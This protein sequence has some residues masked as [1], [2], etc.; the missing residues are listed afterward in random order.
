MRNILLTVVMAT[1]LVGCVG[2][3]DT[4]NPDPGPSTGS[5]PGT[6]SNPGGPVTQA[7][8]KALFDSNVYSVLA[9]KC[10][11]CHSSTAPLP[12]APGFVAPTAADGY[13]IAHGYGA[14][15]GDLS[16]SAP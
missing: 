6:G 15:V 13:N 14:L 7:Q 9:A 4:T 11:S 3:I 12:H 16:P 8:S 1:G 10:K 2:G 5:D